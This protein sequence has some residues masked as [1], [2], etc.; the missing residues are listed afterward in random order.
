MRRRASSTGSNQESKS[1][2]TR[3]VGYVQTKMGLWLIAFT[4]WALVTETGL[5]AHRAVAGPVD[6]ARALW[7]CLLDG[8]LV[9]DMGATL[10]RVALGVGAGFAA[11]IPIGL[12]AGGSRNGGEVESFLD[13]FR[14][15]PPLLVFPIL[16]LAFGYGNEARV[17]V[18]A[19][20][21]LLVV[22]LHVAAAIRQVP[23]ARAEYVATLELTRWQ[24]FKWFQFYATLPGILTSL[25]HAIASGLIVAVVTEMVIGAPHGLGSR[26]V[27]AQMSYDAPALYA[28]VLVTGAL[29]AGLAALILQI[30]QKVVFWQRKQR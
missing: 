14:A 23:R 9:A 18:V 7:T 10:V 6:T 20:A 24:R 21:A 25:R 19:F 11:G 1:A 27:S 15:I 13:F 8:T 4:L 16:L 29:G 30:E 22:S 2:F 3:L 12:W 28:L 26:A 17:A 5:L